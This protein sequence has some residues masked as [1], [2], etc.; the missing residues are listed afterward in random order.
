MTPGKR[1]VVE[2]GAEAFVEMLNANGVDYIFLNPGTDTFP[3]QEALAK[4]QAQEK[5]VPKVILS[6]HESVAMSAA[7]GHFMLSGRPQVVFVHVDLGTQQVGGAL[8]NAQRGRIGVVLCAGRAPWTQDG[9]RRGQRSGM[10]HWIQEQFDQAAIVRGYVKWDYEVRLADNL[11]QVVQRAFQVA[12]ASPP[13]PVYLSLPRE[14]LM[15][16]LEHLE[17]PEVARH[18]APAAPQADAALLEEAAQ[19]LAQAKNPL[20]IAGSPGRNP[21]AVAALVALAEALGAPVVTSD[22]RMNFPSAHPLWAGALANPY[23][24]EADAIL[25]IDHDVPYIPGVVR[26]RPGAKIIQIDLDPVKP[27]IPMWF[28]P[29]D[30]SLHADSA[31]AI[32]VLAAALEGHLTAPARAAARARQERHGQ[33]QQARR[34]GWSQGA[35]RLAAQRPISPDWLGYCIAQAV[36][37]E[38]I[39][40]NEAVTSSGFV[41]RHLARTRPGTIFGSGGSSLG[42]GLGAALGAKLAAPDRTVVSLM[43]DG[44]FVFGCPTAA[45]WA[46][47]AYHVPFLTVIFNNQAYNAPK[48]S[49]RTDYGPSSYSERTGAWVGMDIAPSPEYA[50]VAQACRAYG[51]TVEDPAQLPGALQRGLERVRAGQA[52]VLDVRLQRP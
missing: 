23:L 22:L 35:L 48:A 28:F 24:R 17:V 27:T 31:K 30:I 25:V 47:D 8:H 26:P 2:E 49:L 7:H 16:K 1:V 6:L 12:S 4:F 40:L 10:I 9:S 18:G 44:S 11:H 21:S 41:S 34:E 36:G 15:E 39:V 29:V 13:G 52:A 50:L 20:I 37:E 45:L 51:E 42:W 14:V 32:P 33:Q 3:V 38:D 43:G 46:A 19:I 5:R